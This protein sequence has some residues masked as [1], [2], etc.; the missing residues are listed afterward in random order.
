M[1]VNN[2]LRGMDDDISVNRDYIGKMCSYTDDAS[3]AGSS[4]SYNA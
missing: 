2:M 1:R 4:S 3:K